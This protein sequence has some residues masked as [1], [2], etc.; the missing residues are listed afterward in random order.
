MWAKDLLDTLTD[1]FAAQKPAEETAVRSYTSGIVVPFLVG[2]AVAGLGL[3]A[4]AATITVTTAA[5]VISDDGQCSLREAV[6]AANT[7]SALFSTAGECIAGSGTDTIVLQAATT[8]ILSLDDDGGGHQTDSGA[9]NDDLDIAST[10]TLQGNGAGIQRDTSVTCNPDNTAAKGEFRLF[11]VQST[12]DLQM[13]DVGLYQGCAD[14]SGFP[15]T[16]GGGVFV[17]AGGQFKIANAQISNNKATSLGGGVY[18]LS[19]VTVT[20]SEISSNG[21]GQDGGG[22]YNKGTLTISSTGISDNGAGQN[23]GGLY[24]DSGGQAT[25][26]SAGISSNGA[27][28]DGGGLYNKGTLTISN[29]GISDNGAGQNGGGLYNDSGG[30]VTIT[31]AG[32]STNGVGQDGGGL[33][34]KGTLTIDVTGISSNNA[35]QNGGGLYNDSGGTATI[36]ATEISFNNTPWA[37]GGLYVSSSSTVSLTNST[38]S[39]NS[40]GQKGG[41]IHN[42][43]TVKLSFV[44][45][46]SNSASSGGGI[47]NNATANIRQSIVA[48]SPSG[49]NC[50]GSLT[51]SG[52]NFATDTSCGSGFTSVTPAVLNLGPLT[53]NGGSTQTHALQVPSAAIDAVPSGQCTDLNGNP[54]NQDQRGSGF[55]RPAGARCDAGAYEQQNP[56]TPTPTPT[57]TPPPTP[58]P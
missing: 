45:V 49:N 8:Y 16:A 44:T 21:A 26:T 40:A 30:K 1:I 34:N 17:D 48:I 22:L 41:G 14:G 20:D 27:G 47:F 42:L 46:A 9:D 31:S 25:I 3:P 5:D 29:A 38:L 43:G 36:T 54:V 15:H 24:N 51:A 19:T 13:K 2:V 23:G 28:Q 11:H 33:Y 50:S 57:P 56:P 32:I 58:R 18:S 4:Q 10:I 53:N 35:G 7:D 37:G 55:P 39:G 12:G 6:I 52:V